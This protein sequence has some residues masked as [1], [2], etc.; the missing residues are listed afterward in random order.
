ML[1]Q[2]REPGRETTEVDLPTMSQ[3]HNVNNVNN[4]NH[5]ICENTFNNVNSV[6][7]VNNFIQEILRSQSIFEIPKQPQDLKPLD[8]DTLRP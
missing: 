8:L 5:Y 1:S 4:V 3:C 2:E 6:N 7:N